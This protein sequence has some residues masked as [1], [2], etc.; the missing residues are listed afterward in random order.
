MTRGLRAA[1]AGLGL[2]V[3]VSFSI[4]GALQYVLS[5]KT[6]G[7]LAGGTDNQAW[8]FFQLAT[9]HQRLQVALL[10]V[11]AGVG[12][13]A[14][15]ERRYEVFVSRLNIVRAGTYKQMFIGKAFYDSG[16]AELARFVD[17]TDALAGAS[18]GFDATVVAALLDRVPSLREPIQAM[19][20]GIIG[21][22]A[23]EAARR[24]TEITAM[25]NLATLATVIQAAL[26]AIFAALA[27]WYILQSSRS[28]RELLRLTETLNIAKQGAEA[29]SRAK[30]E[31]LANI[32][33]EIR[34]PLN[35]VMGL[36]GLVVDSDLTGE[37]GSHA[38]SALRSAE[39]L[40]TIVN[41][42]LDLSK[43]EAGRIEVETEDFLLTQPAEDV[44]SILHPKAQQNGNELAY[45]VDPGT[46]LSL[47]GD[48]GRIRQI[49]FNLV[50]NAVKFTQNG[51]IGIRFSTQPL[52]GALMLVVEVSD[53]GIGIPEEFLAHLF[54]RFSQADGSTTRR[55]GGTGL[56]LAICRQLCL[57]QGGDIT[58]RSEVGKGSTFTFTI[59]CQPG[60]DIA[61]T[62]AESPA[63]TPAE[64]I[65]RSPLHILVVDDIDVNRT[66][67]LA[68]LTRRHHTVEIATNGAEAL[69][70]VIAAETPHDLVLMDIQMPVMD[71][72]SA[73][74]A[75]R[76]LPDPAGGIPIIAVTAH[77]M[78]GDRERYI[79]AGMN[80]YVSKPVRPADLFAAI[81]R[82]MGKPTDQPA[83]LATAPSPHSAPPDDL[84]DL[85]LL[86]QTMLDQLRDCLDPEDLSDMLGM[87]PDQA[88]IQAGEI[89][90]ANA[91]DDPAAVKRAA[92][93]MKG[94]NANLGAH[95]L[96]AI[97][98]AIEVN[99]ADP[100][101]VTRLVTL[102]RAQ[103]EPTRRAL[104]EQ[105]LPAPVG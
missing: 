90:A 102:A 3:I 13:P 47:R 15:A 73:T 60:P 57:L 41:D 64:A 25:Q 7:V 34:T 8:A 54:E 72:C 42:I 89:E 63:E 79:A 35:G 48:V 10:E 81:E 22:S 75:I 82:V 58:V 20:L 51:R 70:A 93:G 27:G 92:H 49:L 84:A 96:S 52:D 9:E 86:D 11:S 65:G 61:E 6:T 38:S 39:N 43:L 29:A 74:E 14:A 55:Y 71:G 28:R 37:T 2:A 30:S 46:T 45:T 53:T 36:L 101:E 91:A 98:R 26:C 83:P 85:P 17:E 56:G 68:L 66:L 1:L 95:R 87:F 67:M 21:V 62:V 50:G 97:A 99:A 44:V 78:A 94:A 80:D 69:A 104:G 4:V 33:H 100:A 105:F 32:S 59:R 103:I 24:W 23:N 40:L 88:R 5:N 76:T 19:M 16:I 31:F 12:D 77:A 18:G